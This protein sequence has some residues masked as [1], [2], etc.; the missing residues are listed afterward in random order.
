MGNCI[1][2]KS[3]AYDQQHKHSSSRISHS[4]KSYG[5]DQRPTKHTSVLL[6][7]SS[8]SSSTLNKS[9][10]RSNMFLSRLSD[11]QEPD[12][13]LNNNDENEKKLI[14]YSSPSLLTST[15]NEQFVFMNT[16]SSST[17][18]H[19]Q[20]SSS[21]CEKFKSN[22]TLINLDENNIK[23]TY[24]STGKEHETTTIEHL[25]S[26]KKDINKENNNI[27]SNDQV[28]IDVKMHL[29]D[30]DQN[31]THQYL[32]ILNDQMLNNK[33]IVNTT[34][35]TQGKIVDT[36]INNLFYDDKLVFRID[37]YYF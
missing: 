37:Y 16:S 10:E 28:N 6:L 31:K 15:A 5:N 32:T 29:F 12:I 24:E 18:S 21:E 36:Y 33:M 9:L 20:L 7:L 17:L 27:N 25:F 4:T 8:S 2:K 35:T 23:Q 11:I 26:K 22:I 19:L 14:Q 3:T 30:N 1:G 13:I 34:E